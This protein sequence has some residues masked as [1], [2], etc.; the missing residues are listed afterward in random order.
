MKGP[1]QIHIK[2]FHLRDL[3]WKEDYAAMKQATTIIVMFSVYSFSV[4]MRKSV[5]LFHLRRSNIL[6][7][8]TLR[9]LLLIH[10]GDMDFN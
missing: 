2:T 9:Y 3:T 4:S 10:L 6:C 7:V 5:K 1:S 8:Y